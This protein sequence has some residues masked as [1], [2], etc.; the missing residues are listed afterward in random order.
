LASAPDYLEPTVAW[1]TWLVVEA[2]EGVRLSSVVYPTLWPPRRELVAACRHRRLSLRRPWRRRST[3][4]G[5]PEERC[6]CGIY[7]TVHAGDAAGYLE[8]H[9]LVS[10][11][12]RWPL[13][14]RAIGRV[15]LWGAV[16]ECEDGW[17]AACAYP[18]R[19]FV[20]VPAEEDELASDA[21]EVADGLAVYGVEVALLR[22]RTY[23]E[24]ALFDDR[25]RALLR[26]GH[27]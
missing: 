18:E 6:R 21:R 12:R 9:V 8:G 13:L 1:R 7:G 25:F 20:P 27:G 19:L 14:R 5:A 3:D 26:Q 17:R 23:A 15:F 11:P 16:V 2:E 22:R 4:H 24:N 10:E